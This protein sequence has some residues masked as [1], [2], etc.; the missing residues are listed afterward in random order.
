MSFAELL[1][2]AGSAFFCSIV[3]Q[4][5]I[6]HS[7]QKNT[8]LLFIGTLTTHHNDIEIFILFFLQSNVAVMILHFSTLFFKTKR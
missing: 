4:I 5:W 2:A 8:K 7:H 3:R 1:Q 6:P